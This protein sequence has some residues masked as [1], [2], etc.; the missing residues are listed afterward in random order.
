MIRVIQLVPILLE[1]V[2]SGFGCKTKK[3]M[4][5]LVVLAVVAVVVAIAVVAVVAE[6]V[7][8]SVGRQRLSIIQR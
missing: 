5:V 7:V 4:V 3:I 6:F 8:L 2:R 1:P